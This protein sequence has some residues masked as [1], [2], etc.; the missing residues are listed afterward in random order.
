MRQRGLSLR[1]IAA[2]LGVSKGA[3]ER[4]V[5]PEGPKT[6]KRFAAIAPFFSL[7]SSMPHVLE[8]DL[9]ETLTGHARQEL[10]LESEMSKNR[11]MA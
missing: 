4:L 5:G 3:V 1:V 10:G 9:F 11:K 8:T 6:V 2:K 7:H